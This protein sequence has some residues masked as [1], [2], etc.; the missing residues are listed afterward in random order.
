MPFIYYF[1]SIL[2]LK[3]KLLTPFFSI[4]LAICFSNNAIA[5]PLDGYCV[6]KLTPEQARLKKRDTEFNKLVQKNNYDEEPSTTATFFRNGE[7]FIVETNG[8]YLQLK[9]E[10]EEKVI[11]KIINFLK[12]ED[13][14]KYIFITENNWLFI[15][16]DYNNYMMELNNPELTFNLEKIIKIPFYGENCN[17]FERWLEGGCRVSFI[18]H[19]KTLDRA[20]ISGYHPTDTGL[21]WTAIEILAGKIKTI[22]SLKERFVVEA[23][24]PKYNGAILRARLNRALFYDGHKITEL[25]L[26]LPK[27]RFSGQYPTWQVRKVDSY[28]ESE[29]NQTN[30]RIYITNLSFNSK[31]LNFVIE[32]KKE[33]DIYTKTIPFAANV[34]NQNITQAFLSFPDDPRKWGATS[35]S[36]LFEISGKYQTVLK[37]PKS[38]YIPR[39]L[40]TLDRVRQQAIE[41]KK[42]AL[43]EPA[44]VFDVVHKKTESSET[45]YVKKNTSS[46]Q[47]EILLDPD[48]PLELTVD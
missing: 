4:L 34:D 19:S 27:K 41:G 21:K 40:R 7:K 13:R 29:Q 31:H 1:S 20:I 43:D 46:G 16:A 23:D 38:Y 35:N 44:I 25:E 36:I 9:K 18:S 28:R 2:R 15:H 39:Y 11:Q 10:G 45:Y 32:V 5:K 37:I 24:V 47:C 33:A 12:A 48:N 42:M 6:S 30:E 8:F 3:F 14:I 17:R 22:T 26:D